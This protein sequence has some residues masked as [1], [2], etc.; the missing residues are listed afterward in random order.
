M[1]GAARPRAFFQLRRRPAHAGDAAPRRGPVAVCDRPP[2]RELGDVSPA[3]TPIL[4]QP[5]PAR[6]R[7]E[8]RVE[9]CKGCTFCVEY[10]P[11]DVLAVS[12][13]FNAKGYHYPVVISDGC[14]LCQACAAVCPEFAIFALPS[15]T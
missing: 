8:I 10:C 11:V 12:T 1:P 3:R 14:I 15:H 13:D 4:P 2:P 9:R 5:S 7:V 6:G